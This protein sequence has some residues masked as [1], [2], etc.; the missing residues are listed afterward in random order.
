[1]RIPFSLRYLSAGLVL[2][3]V[4]VG[5]MSSP[6]NAAPTFRVGQVGTTAAVNNWPS[7]ESPVNVRDA[8]PGTKYL[9]FLKLDTGVIETFPATTVV[10]GIT[11]AS[12][13]DATERDPMTF[14]LYGSTTATVT[15]SEAAGTTI[16]L[17]TYTPIVLNQP[18]TGMQ[19]TPA[20]STTLANQAIANAVAYRSYAIIFPTVRNAA[21]AN[22]MQIGDVTFTS[23]GTAIAGQATNPVIGGAVPEP[24]SAGLFA[25]AALRLL[26]RRRRV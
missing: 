10:D 26:A 24:T 6:A 15:G 23:G 19:V 25:L 12:A 1:M 11:F 13:N 18:I 20:R 2:V 9:N 22:S 4:V 17:G 14:S 16:D 5:A 3:V 21:T 8:A 7:A